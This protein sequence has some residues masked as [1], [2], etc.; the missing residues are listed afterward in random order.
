MSGTK[1]ECW[2]DDEEAPEVG[3]GEMVSAYAPAAAAEYYA[4]VGAMEDGEV[5]RICVR[6]DSAI[7]CFEIKCTRGADVA[8]VEVNP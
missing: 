1:Y 2:D 7:K 5:R 6:V 4:D 8:E 3:E